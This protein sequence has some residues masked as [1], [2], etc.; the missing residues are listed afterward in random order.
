[1]KWKH[2]FALLAICAG[3]SPAAVQASDAGLWRFLWSA[4][5]QN[6]EWAIEIPVIWDAI[7]LIMTSP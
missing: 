6:V 4:P 5:E 1:M 3:I 7:T 2:F